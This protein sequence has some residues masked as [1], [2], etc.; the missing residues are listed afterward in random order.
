MNNYQNI[1]HEVLTSIY[2]N[3]HIALQ[4]ISNVIGESDHPDLKKELNEEYD[5]YEKFIGELSCYMKEIGLEPKDIG[6]MKKAFMFTAIK[7]NTMT[8]D[9]KSHIAE[10]MIKGTVMGITE[11]TEIKNGH[12]NELGE[13]TKCFLNKLLSLEEE[14]EQRLKQLL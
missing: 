12:G 10:L 3:A 11:L 4:S 14:Y 5:G 7:M 1:D 6:V 9:S 8:N 13:K 2:K